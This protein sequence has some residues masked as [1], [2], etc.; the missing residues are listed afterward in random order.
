[1]TS[2]ARRGSGGENKMVAALRWAPLGK[3][4]VSPR[5]GRGALAKGFLCR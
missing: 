1:M 2:P 4:A 3:G 5:L